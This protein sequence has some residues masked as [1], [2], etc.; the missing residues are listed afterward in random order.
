VQPCPQVR[1]SGDAVPLSP[2]TPWSAQFQPRSPGLDA[3]HSVARSTA[4]STASRYGKEA[5][6][7]GNAVHVRLPKGWFV[8]TPKTARLGYS[9]VPAVQ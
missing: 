8:G 7:H 6:M 9:A 1:G 4:A 3:A 2:T 5:G